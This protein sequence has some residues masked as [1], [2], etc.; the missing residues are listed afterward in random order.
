MSG[1]GEDRHNG[2][3]RFD[4]GWGYGVAMVLGTTAEGIPAGAYGWDGGM[5][6]T[7]GGRSA[8]RS[9]R[10]PHDSDQV[11][12]PDLPQMHKDFWRAAF[13]PGDS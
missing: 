9:D 8:L 7:L 2:S 3:D 5:G 10:D 4:R 1:A 11:H 12:Q 13:R 6:T